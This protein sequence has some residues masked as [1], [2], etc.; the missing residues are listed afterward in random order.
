MGSSKNK[1]AARGKRPKEPAQS[2]SKSNDLAQKAK[3]PTSIPDRSSQSKLIHPNPGPGIG[4]VTK[5]AEEKYES[6]HVLLLSFE[7]SDLDLEFDLGGISHAFQRLG[8]TVRHYQIPTENSA[9]ELDK[10][11]EDFFEVKDNDSH[12]L[13][14]LYYNG[15]GGVRG[16]V[17]LHF[18]NSGSSRT[19]E[20]KSYIPWEGIAN[21]VNQAN[22]DTLVV[23]DCCDAGRGATRHLGNEVLSSYRKEIIGACA[24]N[25]STVDHM[26]PTLWTVLND[27]LLDTEDSMST[28]TL[29]QRMNDS[30][31]KINNERAPQ[32]VHYHLG[33]R[34]IGCI[35]L[36]RLSTHIPVDEH[37]IYECYKKRIGSSR[38]LRDRKVLVLGGESGIGRS[39][40]IAFALEGANVTIAYVAERTQDAQATQGEAKNL[41]ADGEIS[42]YPFLSGIS[43][44]TLRQSLVSGPNGSETIDIFL[45][46]IGYKIDESRDELRDQDDPLRDPSSELQPPEPLKL[47]AALL[48]GNGFIHAALSLANE[49]SIIINTLSR[50]SFADVLSQRE[51]RFSARIVKILTEYQASSKKFKGTTTAVLPGVD[52]M[53]QTNIKSALKILAAFASAASTDLSER[54]SISGQVTKL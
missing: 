15:H 29:V 35:I 22:C 36:P 18:A 39:A 17:K 13:R 52:F 24:W 26:S 51:S 31:V 50:R 8:Y 49:N 53:L 34:D 54:S 28:V 32:A 48:E 42:L 9:V 41:R 3:K 38:K 5:D 10:E 14:I 37:K 20:P 23:L 19:K 27:G 12:E 11:L 2:E 21:K 25:I 45:N 30:L 1:Q 46:N 40:A 4:D 47:M 6:V 7:E 16:G 44:D 33:R 43:A